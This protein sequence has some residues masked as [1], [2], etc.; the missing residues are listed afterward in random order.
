MKWIVSLSGLLYVKLG[1][2]IIDSHPWFCSVQITTLYGD[3]V[4]QAGGYTNKR[5][6]RK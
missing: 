3:L 6:T 2:Q 1:S 4:K 5:I